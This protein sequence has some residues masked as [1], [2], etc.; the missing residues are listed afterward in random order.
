MLLGLNGF[1]ASLAAYFGALVHGEGDWLDL[2]AQECAAGMLELYGPR[3]RLRR[4]CRRR[5][6]ATA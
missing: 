5:G 4:H 2:S 6:S 3:A 1:S